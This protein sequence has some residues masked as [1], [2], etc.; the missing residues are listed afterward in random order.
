MTARQATAPRIIPGIRWRAVV[1]DGDAPSRALLAETVNGA[2]GQVVGN[3]SRL[4][5][6]FLL[7]D[8][9]RP[10]AAIL[11][12]SLP[13]GD[14]L[15]GARRL[16]E[17][18]SCAVILHTDEVEAETVTRAAASGVLGFLL[19]PL[20]TEELA[21]VLDVAVARF[22]ELAAVRKENLELRRT[23]ETRKL[24]ERA[25]GILMLRL[26]LSEP[27]AFR[28]IQKTAMDTRRPMADVAQALLLTEELGQAR[29]AS[30]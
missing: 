6:A 2:G 13:D 12:A 11:A 19:K 26:G 15:D 7:V 8:R 5:D 16:A 10:D 18:G 28:R 22:R 29:A 20:R 27:E 14:G 1:V 30:K 24:I 9:W 23:L 4:E 25:K 17:S 21:P 3:G